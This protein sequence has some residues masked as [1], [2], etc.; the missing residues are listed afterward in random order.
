[1]SDV[2]TLIKQLNGELPSSGAMLPVAWDTLDSK[3]KDM[4]ITTLTGNDFSYSTSMDAA[5]RLM[6][7][8]S[9]FSLE[10]W[11]NNELG[12]PVAGKYRC[13]AYRGMVR[14]IAEALTPQDAICKAFLL[15]VGMRVK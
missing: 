6:E 3:Q 2:E 7:G 15:A 13:K 10:A 12:L 11:T 1:M 4:L 5:M 9:E 14:H 8:F